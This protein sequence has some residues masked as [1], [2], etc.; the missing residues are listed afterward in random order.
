MIEKN[1]YDLKINKLDFK[2]FLI[3]IFLLASAPF[4]SAIIFLYLTI[5][6]TYKSF[7][8]VIRDKYNLVIFLIS[9]IMLIQCVIYTF[10]DNTAIKQWDSQLHWA[11]IANWIPLFLLFIGLQPYLSN[12]DN[13]LKTA[14]FFIAGSFPV[15]A[16]CLFQF[17]FGWHGPYETLNGLIKWFQVP[18]GGEQSVTGLFNNPNYTGSWLTLIFPLLLACL[19]DKFRKKELIKFK[20]LLFIIS[21][22]TFSIIL[23]NSR[24]AFIGLI[25]SIP[26]IF[27][28][29]IIKSFN[30][31]ILIVL[32]FLSAYYFFPD[33]LLNEIFNN[34]FFKDNYLISKFTSMFYSLNNEIR[35]SIWSNA[36]SYIQE[37]PLFGW[38]SSSF[39]LLFRIQNNIWYGHTHNL[40]LELAVSYGLIISLLVFSFLLNIIYRSYFIVFKNEENDSLIDKGYW[41]GSFIFFIA[42]L[43]DVLYF[44]FRLNIATWIFLAS[45]KSIIDKNNKPK[46][47]SKFN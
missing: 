10:V 34:S 47:L 8:S 41:A 9:L 35:I 28:R 12:E 2:I 7:Y 13:R 30:F 45:L 3:A 17:I 46:N 15:I 18:Y 21:T 16:S 44:D 20:I 11:G 19:K 24:A 38:G 33:S 42:Q 43:Y 31:L 6:G 36:I 5:K 23:T 26:I 27:G 37:K 25:I 39:P 40:F 1:S 22:F 14:K 29:R 32:I 4:F